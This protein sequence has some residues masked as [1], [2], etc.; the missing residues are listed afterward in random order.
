[1]PFGLTLDLAATL[2]QATWNFFV[3]WINGGPELV[4]LFSALST[5]LYLPLAIAIVVLQEVTCDLKQSLFIAGSVALHLSY[6][7]LL[8]GGLS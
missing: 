8:Q 6:V 2:C 7:L 1:M 5:V 3:K 4:W